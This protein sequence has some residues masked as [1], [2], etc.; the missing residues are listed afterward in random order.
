MNFLEGYSFWKGGL[1]E[2]MR[3]N[4]VSA[5]CF[6]GLNLTSKYGILGL[7]YDYVG[8]YIYSFFIVVI[9]DVVIG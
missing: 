8:H 1:T 9:I 5:V 4:D 6:D 2:I 3:W 7:C